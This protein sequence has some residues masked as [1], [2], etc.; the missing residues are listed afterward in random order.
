MTDSGVCVN[1]DEFCWTYDS[2][3]VCIE[4]APNYYMSKLQNKC[5]PRETGCLYDENDRCYAC[6][7][8][9]Y[10]DGV[11]CEIYGCMKLSNTGC[12]ICMYPM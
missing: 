11:R 3:G 4:C 5:L 7:L 1:K 8:P 10:F 2:N 12:S 6:D 9:F